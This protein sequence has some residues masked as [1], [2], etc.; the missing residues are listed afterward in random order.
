MLVYVRK[1]TMRTLRQNL[2]DMCENPIYIVDTLHPYVLSSEFRRKGAKRYQIIAP[3]VYRLM[4]SAGA[5]DG[6]FILAPCNKCDSCRAVRR[7]Q[8]VTRAILEARLHESN[9]FVTLTYD[10]DH[11]HDDKLCYRDFQLFMKRLRKALPEQKIRFLVCGEYGK[12]N[13]RP[14]WHVIFFNLTLD[15]LAYV[16]KRRKSVFYDSKLLRDVWQNGF[17][18]ITKF[19]PYTACYVTKYA[20]KD[21]TLQRQSNRPGL[22]HGFL[23]AHGYKNLPS[24]VPVAYVRYFMRV[25]K[26]QNESEWLSFR[27]Y[28]AKM[29]K[30]RAM[31][32]GAPSAPEG[33]GSPLSRLRRCLDYQPCHPDL[34]S[35]GLI[36]TSDY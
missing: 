11:L 16:C 7:A 32:Q 31:L 10:D 26:S 30:S 18:S 5:P 20:C 19:N 29:A 3:D 9:L 4:R 34:T 33:R 17:V 22:A 24:D 36:F 28:Q 25:L 1:I 23:E 8:W 14:H 15:D 21:G 27:R 13:G 6:A 12:L 35:H 2:V